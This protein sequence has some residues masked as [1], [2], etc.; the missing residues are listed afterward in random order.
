MR[1]RIHKA[2]L[3]GL[4]EAHPHALLTSMNC[5]IA[6]NVVDCSPPTPRTLAEAPSLRRQPPLE[7]RVNLLCQ[8]IQVRLWHVAL[9]RSRRWRDLA[10]G[11]GQRTATLGALRTRNIR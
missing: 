5:T 10:F 2:R 1:Q 6:R 4:P 9:V 11:V 7:N 8:R 3:R